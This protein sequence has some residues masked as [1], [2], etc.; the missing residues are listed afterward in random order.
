MEGEEGGLMDGPDRELGGGGTLAAGIVLW[1]DLDEV[2]VEPP[3]FEGD[4]AV[5]GDDFVEL[6]L[7]FT[8]GGGGFADTEGGGFG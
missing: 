1:G 4:G 5:G 7:K 8:S 3:E 2:A 6:P